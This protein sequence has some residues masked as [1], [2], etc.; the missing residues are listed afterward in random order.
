M[1][2]LSCIYLSCAT[3][4]GDEWPLKMT[5][6]TQRFFI[7]PFQSGISNISM[8]FGHLFVSNPEKLTFFKRPL[9]GNFIK[10]NFLQ[11]GRNGI[12]AKKMGKYAHPSLPRACF[13]WPIWAKIKRYRWKDSCCSTKNIFITKVPQ[14]GMEKKLMKKNC[15]KICPCQFWH[16]SAFLELVIGIVLN[17]VALQIPFTHQKIAL[18][19]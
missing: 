13:T 9:V 12:W 11:M 10:Q 16:F 19:K 7:A 15:P 8:T 3:T 4:N 1:F 2:L 18:E 14:N 17:W 6:L 5:A